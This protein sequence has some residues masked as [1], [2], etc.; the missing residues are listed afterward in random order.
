MYTELLEIKKVQFEKAEVFEKNSSFE[1]AYL[2]Y[3][4]VLEKILKVIETRRKRDNFYNSICEW[5]LFLETGKGKTP[6][7]IKL[8]SLKEVEKMPEISSIESFIGKTPNVRKIMNTQS[9]NGSTKWR[10]KRNNIAHQSDSFGSENKYNEY[11][12][13]IIQGIAEIETVLNKLKT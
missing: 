11:K 6:V 12:Q 7:K 8:F 1:M 13:M 10:D 2:S 9:K 3:W 5:K 4:I